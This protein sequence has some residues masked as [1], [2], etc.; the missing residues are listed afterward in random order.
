[1]NAMHNHLTGW[2]IVTCLFGNTGAGLAPTAHK[3][4]QSPARAAP[5]LLLR[6]AGGLR[7][8]HHR[9]DENRKAAQDNGKADEKLLGEQKRK[10]SQETHTDSREANEKTD[11]INAEGFAAHNG[12]F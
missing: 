2:N 10:H 11:G 6:A 4:P 5:R 8:H 7:A 1:M 9:G 12:Y 3:N